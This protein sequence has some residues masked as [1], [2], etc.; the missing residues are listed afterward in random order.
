M[1][2]SIFNVKRQCLIEELDK[3]S[4]SYIYVFFFFYKMV[5]LHYGDKPFFLV[6]NG[7]L[8]YV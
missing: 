1:Y 4:N 5:M 6:K 7:N 8:T 3:L 2:F